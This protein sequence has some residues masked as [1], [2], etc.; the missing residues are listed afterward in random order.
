MRVRLL[1]FCLPLLLLLMAPKAFGQNEIPCQQALQLA[2]QEYDEGFFENASDRLYTCIGKGVF[3]DEE[4]LRAY[5]LL[6]RI[7]YANL[8]H[9]EARDSIRRALDINP[10]IELDMGRDKPGFVRMMEEIR[11]DLDIRPLPPRSGF[12]FSL[13]I[14]PANAEIDCN[15]CGLIA[16]D[17]PWNGGSG[18][19]FHLAMGGTLS[20]N[21]Q[22]GGELNHWGT[23][24]NQDHIANIN[25]LSLVARYYPKAHGQFY[26]RGGVGL[27]GATIESKATDFRLESGGIGIQLGLGYD[28]LLGQRKRVALSPYLNMVAF[29]AEGELKERDDLLF[30]GPSNP[31]FIQLGVAFVVL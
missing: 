14:G 25:I 24:T 2:M 29:G 23:P 9:A 6:G 26:F 12:W 16:D 11:A 10:A 3:T 8:Q 20:P 15:G 31:G 17:D 22:L 7:H 5:L 27:G 18:S 4:E 19:S 30:R 28:V 13:G 21:W 1:T